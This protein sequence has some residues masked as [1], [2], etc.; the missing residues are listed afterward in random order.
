MCELGVF[1]K[2]HQ[3]GPRRLGSHFNLESRA[4]KYATGPISIQ[5]A[6]V[7]PQ[8]IEIMFV[9]FKSYRAKSA[10]PGN[11]VFWL[12]IRRVGVLS[13]TSIGIT[14]TAVRQAAATSISVTQGKHCDRLCP[15]FRYSAYH[16]MQ[17]PRCRQDKQATSSFMFVL[18]AN[19]DAL[20][21]TLAV[22]PRLSSLNT[23]LNT[24]SGGVMNRKATL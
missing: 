24:T 19:P 14:G 8:S 1:R 4:P 18:P 6:A 5:F 15:V 22:H 21:A 2:C 10:T 23:E 3:R 17:R 16:P 20:G 9:L 13:P 7:R 11:L 12:M